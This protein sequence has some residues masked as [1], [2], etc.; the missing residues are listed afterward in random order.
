[1]AYKQPDRIYIN[2]AASA[3]ATSYS[4]QDDPQ[5]AY[6]PTSRSEP[7]V[8][9][10]A[11]YKLSVV[12]AV[13]QGTSNFPVW[14]PAV[15]LGQ[16]N[17]N[18]TVY[19]FTM[20]VSFP[21]QS[22]KSGGYTVTT[23]PTTGTTSY[24]VSVTL[25]AFGLVEQRTLTVTAGG[26]TGTA[27][28]FAAAFQLAFSS[29]P[30]SSSVLRTMDV[31]AVG[32]K[33]QFNWAVR[34]QP[35]GTD[36]Y[37]VFIKPTGV[38]D[39]AAS[40]LDPVAPLVLFPDSNFETLAPFDCAYVQPGSLTTQ[41]GGTFSSTQNLMWI[42][43]NTNAP[44]PAPPTV[45]QP[46]TP[47]YWMYDYAWFVRIM[48]N[49]LLA[50]T[51]DILTQAYTAGVEIPNVNGSPTFYPGAVSV[52]YSPSSQSFQLTAPASYLYPS[53]TPFAQVPTLTMRLNEI[54]LNLLSWPAVIYF[55]GDGTLIW[56]NATVDYAT[57]QSTLTSDYPAVGSGWSPVGSLVF[58]SSFFPVRTE[59][60]SAPQS[61][62]A[63]NQSFDSSTN[64]QSQI[65]TDVFP[66]FANA[67]DWNAVP[68]IYQPTVLRWV[69]L[70]AG[71][72]SLDRVDFRL[73]WRNA[74]TGN[75]TPVTLNP[76]ASFSVKILLALKDIPF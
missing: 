71:S 46:E 18:K 57:D 73:G 23:P 29:I 35:P 53:I 25:G 59:I 64:D 65:L 52:Q 32:T 63:G 15:E 10:I 34:P 7:I 39:A 14:I 72:G 5:A 8:S 6:I 11:N 55:N 40:G 47:Y 68:I 9:N 51:N 38:V 33:L 28:G 50:A 20:M 31:T 66:A 74:I 22:V 49:A 42:P 27:A 60:L 26:T 30:D 24:S 45:V 17:I 67:A 56:D 44:I 37:F 58:Q 75:I 76:S 3:S 61:Y 54:L 16:S 69:D 13:L 43:Q 12:R 21:T 4:L 41:L 70:P 36:S 1:M 48:N 62:G 19:Q 2:L